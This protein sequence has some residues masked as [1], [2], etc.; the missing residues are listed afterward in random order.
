M[1]T[2]LVALLVTSFNSLFAKFSGHVSVQI[3]FA[4][5]SEDEISVQIE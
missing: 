3:S 1:E 4:G 5:V 2:P